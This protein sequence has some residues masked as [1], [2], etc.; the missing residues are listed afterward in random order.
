MKAKIFVNDWVDQV[1]RNAGSEGDS[2]HF[3]SLKECDAH[4]I[5]SEL[6]CKALEIINGV[7]SHIQGAESNSNELI[8]LVFLPLGASDDILLWED[9][10]WE[11]LGTTNEPPSLYLMQD[12]QIFDENM[13]EYRRPISVPPIHGHGTVRAVF[14]S[15]R[16]AEAMKNLWE[17]TSG[18]YLVARVD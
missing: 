9:E 10:L 4:Q 2:I 14:R 7:R 18:I 1:L 5:G 12:S 17:F 8:A 6:V 3:S 13:E 16:D 15:F 11:S